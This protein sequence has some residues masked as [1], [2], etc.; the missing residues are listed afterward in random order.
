MSINISEWLRWT[1]CNTQPTLFEVR[2][3]KNAF[4]DFETQNV[5][6]AL[7]YTWTCVICMHLACCYVWTICYSPCCWHSHKLGLN[8]IYLYWICSYTSLDACRNDRQYWHISC[9]LLNID[10]FIEQPEGRHVKQAYSDIAI[11][12]KFTIKMATDWPHKSAA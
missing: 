12:L 3:H 6:N 1:L 10:L 5:C 11:A 9:N 2:T 7:S 8:D 4:W